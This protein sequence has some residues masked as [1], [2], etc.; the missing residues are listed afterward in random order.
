[1]DIRD[2][3]DIAAQ[4]GHLAIVTTSR[5][6]GSIQ[7]S[8]VSAGLTSHPLTG[9]QVLGLVAIGGSVKLRNL[10]RVPRATAV[11]RSGWEWVALEGHASLIGP[12]DRLEGFD[13][14]RLPQFL[15]DVF[16]AA[17]GT[18]DD[19]PTYDR[20]MADERRT[21]VLIEPTRVYGNRSA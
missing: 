10:R 16:M 11:F 14:R 9:R 17:G 2:I 13:P 5:D 18:H 21:A 4:A 15:R 6:D 19:W 1:V 12:D 20:V 7:A 3:D 8:V